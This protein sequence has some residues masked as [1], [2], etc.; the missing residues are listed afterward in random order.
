[1]IPKFIKRL[2]GATVLVALVIF[3]FLVAK[4]WRLAAGFGSATVWMLGN[5]AVW[6][7]IAV[8]LTRPVP[9]RRTRL[10]LLVV[11]KLLLLVLGVVGLSLASP[12]SRAQMLAVLAG[13]T[14]V[15]LVAVLKA[16]G[17]LLTGADLFAGKEQ[18]QGAAA[19]GESLEKT[20]N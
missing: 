16:L 17:A 11:A 15:F 6:S 4:D 1:M 12:L 2:I 5:L 7:V 8:T 14:L 20:E 9:A 3:I 10:F 19:P 18:S 13:I